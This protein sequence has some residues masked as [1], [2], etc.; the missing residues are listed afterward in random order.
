MVSKE[1]QVSLPDMIKNS[2]KI[3]ENSYDQSLAQILENFNDSGKKGFI[4]SNISSNQSNEPP[5]QI[6]LTNLFNEYFNNNNINIQNICQFLGQFSIEVEKIL[7]F[8]ISKNE[9]N[10]K[11][12]FILDDSKSNSNILDEN[13]DNK[14]KMNINSDK[15]EQEI[16]ELKENKNKLNKSK[17]NQTENLTKSSKP[18]FNNYKTFFNVKQEKNDSNNDFIKKIQILIII[19][20]ILKI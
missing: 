1:N 4:R 16:K 11:C 2:P 6:S 3:I 14:N 12:F 13:N 19:N 20:N 10:S 17:L 7:K 18:N 15:K 5:I 9:N 8:I